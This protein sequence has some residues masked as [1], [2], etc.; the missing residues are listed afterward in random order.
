MEDVINKTY[1]SDPWETITDPNT[2]TTSTVPKTELYSTH[3]ENILRAENG[4]PLR[5]YYG[6]YT[7]GSGISQTRLIT[8]NTSL[9]IQLNGTTNY[10]T[11]SKNLRYV[12]K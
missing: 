4:L 8:G 2:G 3:V 9:Y 6:A 11:V 5:T 7:D 12:Y 1:S 10:K